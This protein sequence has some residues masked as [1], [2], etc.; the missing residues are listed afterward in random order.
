MNGMPGQA[1]IHRTETIL[2]KTTDT[3]LF[4]IFPPCFIS[5]LLGEC[6]SALFT[7]LA[8]P[9]TQRWTLND[10]SSFSHSQQRILLF[11]RII[12]KKS[13]NL[14]KEKNQMKRSWEK[15]SRFSQK[16]NRT[17]AKS[18]YPQTMENKERK[19][20]QQKFVEFFFSIESEEKTKPMKIGCIEFIWK[21]S[22]GLCYVYAAISDGV[23]STSGS[24]DGCGGGGGIER[25]WQQSASCLMIRIVWSVCQPFVERTNVINLLCLTASALWSIHLI[26]II[27][28]DLFHM[29]FFLRFFM[30]CFR[31]SLMCVCEWIAHL[32]LNAAIAFSGFT[33]QKDMQFG[34]DLLY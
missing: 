20:I 23:T 24:V 1:S 26:F 25:W 30:A 10:S 15:K 21:V 27:M 18:N 19:K 9:Q 16:S 31:R 14:E 29:F 8:A 11:Y 2:T 33:L 28:F 22:C 17:T 32:G 4:R 13:S 6:E 5:L 7:F 12:R 34:L 3:C